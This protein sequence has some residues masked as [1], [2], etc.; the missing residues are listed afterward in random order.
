[1]TSMVQDFLA[2][3][4]V[5]VAR[6]ARVARVSSP[7]THGNLGYP[8][9]PE[10]GGPGYR[11]AHDTAEVTAESLASA[12]GMQGNRP[13]TGPVAQVTDETEHLDSEDL[14]DRIEERAAIMTYLAGLP[15]AEA[16]AMAAVECYAA[17]AKVSEDR[18]PP[19]EG[20]SNT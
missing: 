20:R 4:I 2:Y 7:E 13:A 5:A 1:M 16:E 8:P 18:S 12:S 15:D 11:R 9:E 17:L 10:G 14:K 19:P 6:V 3:A